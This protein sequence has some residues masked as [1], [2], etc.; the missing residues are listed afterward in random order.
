MNNN[1][2][3]V[4]VFLVLIMGCF[5]IYSDVMLID[6][7][8]SSSSNRNNWSAIVEEEMALLELWASWLLRWQITVFGKITSP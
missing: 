7:L 2:L 5:D 8:A 1:G 3:C 6:T 4:K